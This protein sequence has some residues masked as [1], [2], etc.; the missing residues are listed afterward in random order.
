MIHN[1]VGKAKRTNGTGVPGMG[2]YFKRFSMPRRLP[3]ISLRTRLLI[4]SIL[5][6]LASTLAVGISSY[7]QARNT[8]I[9]TVEDRLERE[10]EVMAYVV[11]NLKFVYVS[12]DAYFK[13]QVD[14][15]I[16]EQKRQLDGHGYASDFFY[17]TA[18]E[19]KAFQASR[20]SELALGE[21][22]IAHIVDRED[23]VFHETIGGHDYTVSVKAM[24][25][26]DG[27]YVLLV[28]T[29]SYLGPISQ[30]AEFTSI[31][32]VVS[33]VVSAFVVMWF[34]RTLTHPLLKLQQIMIDVRQGNLKQA[35]AIHTKMPEI[36]SLKDSFQM[37]LEQM[38]SMILELN[39]RTGDLKHTGE[40]LSRSSH[41]TLTYSNE[42]IDAINAVQEGA[43]QTASGSE[44]SLEG[45]HE[46]NEKIQSLIAN[47]QQVSESSGQMDDSAKRG[48][49]SVVELIETIQ[50]HETDVSQISGVVQEVRDHSASIS[51][52]VVLIDEVAKQTKL[53]AL[54]ASIE[55]AR[56]GE[57]G[58]GFSVVATEIRKLAD[59]SSIA[60]DVITKSIRNMELVT[61]RASEEFDRMIGKIKENL[62]TAN[63]SKESFDHLMREIVTVSN[64]VKGVQGELQGL[65]VALPA[66]QELMMSFAAV[67]E[68]TFA[69]SQQMLS[70]SKDQIVHMESTHQI[71]QQLTN[72]ADSL[73]DKTKKF[74][75]S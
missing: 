12:D 45:F 19:A 67:S 17:V 69:S 46:M 15:S 34:V 36:N 1:I 50:R 59:Q 7:T 14:M 68:E 5:L 44:A 22:L 10:A 56:A 70:I 43:K 37:M 63:T 74:N 47:I 29:D 64:R 75:V 39:E 31:I 25:E 71:G 51:K 72:I 4:L 58:R 3:G 24:P 38:R 48:E 8:L 33:V 41:E 21:S 66:L 28:R 11:R 35:I 20:S 54:N 32:I 27:K 53:L 18:G 62:N 40:K 23:G 52:Q 49:Q 55:A 16:F 6:L 13:Q 42:L 60:A 26:L 30:T 9:S 57:A 2:S 65:I 61:R 73:N